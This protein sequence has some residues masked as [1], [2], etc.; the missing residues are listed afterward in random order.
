MCRWWPARCNALLWYSPTMDAIDRIGKLLDDA[1]TE[2]ANTSMRL[3]TALRDAAAIA[4]EELGAAPSTTALTAE[5]LRTALDALVMQAALDAHFV[6]HPESRLTLG[7][8]AIAAAELDGHPL[9]ADP[10]RLRDAAGQ[11]VR[12]RPDADADDVLLWAEAQAALA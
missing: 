2:T 8:L 11:I 6:Q 10:A 3:P 5:A 7:E 4:V 9:A 1:G 12:R